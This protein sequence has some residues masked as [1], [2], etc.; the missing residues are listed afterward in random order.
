MPRDVLIPFHNIVARTERCVQRTLLF[1][2]YFLRTKFF[3]G[4]RGGL[5]LFG[6]LPPPPPPTHTPGG[7]HTV[8]HTVPTIS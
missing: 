1:G 6:E 3:V 7:A 4:H 2:L 5:E 8:A